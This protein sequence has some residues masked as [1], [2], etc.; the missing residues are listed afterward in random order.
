MK[1]KKFDEMEEEERAKAAFSTLYE[2]Y[3]VDLIK[4]L[5]KQVKFKYEMYIVADGNYGALNEQ[6][7]KWNGMIADLI[8]HVSSVFVKKKDSYRL[9][10]FFR[11]VTRCTLI[12]IN[13][14]SSVTSFVSNYLVF[15]I[16]SKSI[17]VYDIE[18]LFHNQVGLCI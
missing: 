10:T 6:T 17:F 5:S 15:L 3:V 14:I 11:I 7:G 13:I 16:D 2:G 12:M 8:N 9:K 1:T 18:M 4:A